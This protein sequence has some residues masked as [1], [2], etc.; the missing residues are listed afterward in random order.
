MSTSSPTLLE[1]HWLLVPY[2][3]VFKLLLVHEARIKMVSALNIWAPKIWHFFPFN[4]RHS[5]RA[6]QF[7]FKRNFKTILFDQFIEST[8]LVN[9]FH[10]VSKLVIIFRLLVFVLNIPSAQMFLSFFSIFFR[11]LSFQNILSVLARVLEKNSLVA[12]SEQT[13]IEYDRDLISVVWFYQETIVRLSN[14]PNRAVF[15]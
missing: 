2:R 6:S 12:C 10:F 1:L 13:N 15:T 4:M 11:S 8:Y 3:I 5:R 7:Q 9:Q 14:K